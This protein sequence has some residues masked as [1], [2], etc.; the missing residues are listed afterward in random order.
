MERAF[1]KKQILALY[2]NEIYLGQGSYGVAAAALRYFDKALDQL[3]LAEMAYLAALPKAPNNY[4]PVRNL[5]VATARRN[6]VL[7]EMVQNRFIS[8]KEASAAKK[9]P[10]VMNAPS[11]YDAAD[12]PYFTEE[13]RRQLISQFGKK[14]FMTEDCLSVQ[15]L[16]LLTTGGRRCT[17]KRA[18]GP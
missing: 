17:R 16:T 3:T 7:D 5:R 10:I 15:H 11:G 13:V 18:R 12:A 6:W 14:R 8:E 9:V 1:T 2:L 4:H